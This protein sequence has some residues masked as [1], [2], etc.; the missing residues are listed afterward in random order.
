MMGLSPA[1]HTQDLERADADELF[2]RAF[3]RQGGCHTAK[4]GVKDRQTALVCF[5]AER[6]IA[7]SPLPTNVL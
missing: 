2:V 4:R 1:P 7:Q 5:G 3:L 6:I